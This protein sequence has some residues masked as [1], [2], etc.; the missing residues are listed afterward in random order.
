M[1]PTAP[2]FKEIQVP[3]IN[4]DNVSN[5]YNVC[6]IIDNTGSMESWINVIKD[7]CSNLFGEIV[8][9]FNKYNF[10]FGCV[11]YE[12]KISINTVKIIK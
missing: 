12:N 3:I 5:E 6:F 10:S 11:L 2:K 4:R 1:I 8:A 7:I 9:K